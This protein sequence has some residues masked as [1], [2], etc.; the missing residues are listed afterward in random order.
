VVFAGVITNLLNLYLL[1][2]K[3]EEPVISEGCF[4]PSILRIVGA[5]SQRALFGFRAVSLGYP[6]RIAG[7][8]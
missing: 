8:G 1:Y 7:T 4:T 5:T 2:E 3:R 6:K